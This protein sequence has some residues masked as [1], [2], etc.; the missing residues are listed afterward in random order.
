[1][2]YTP[3]KSLYFNPDIEYLFNAEIIEYD[4]QSAGLSLIREYR[5]LPPEKITSLEK[6]DKQERNIVIGKLQRDQAG[7]SRTLLDKFTLARQTFLTEN[8]IADDRIISVR[9]DAIFTVGRCDRTVFGELH[10]T[11]R[12]EYSSYVRFSRNGNLEAY[13]SDSGVDI[14]GIGEMGLSKHRLYLLIFLRKVIGMIEG[15]NQTLKRYLRTFV[16]DY[17]SGKLDDGYY[18]EFNHV[19][20]VLNQLFNYQRLIVPLVQ[21]AVEELES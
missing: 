7:F 12:N 1:M 5:L 16:D 15:K 2:S 11:E 14:K 9:K 13:Y 8:S 17:K 20:Q 4:L 6:L 18:L 10:F 21:I 19:S 3:D